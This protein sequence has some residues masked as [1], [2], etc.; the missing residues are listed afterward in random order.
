MMKTGPYSYVTQELLNEIYLDMMQ[1]PPVG[2]EEKLLLMVKEEMMARIKEKK[3]TFVR[4]RRSDNPPFSNLPQKQT[5]HESTH[6]RERARRL[7]SSHRIETSSSAHCK[8]CL[9]QTS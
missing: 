6:L 7:D 1:H 9:R 4:H 3:Q 8:V 5:H 2:D